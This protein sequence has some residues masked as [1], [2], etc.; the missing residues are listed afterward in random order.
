MEGCR[1]RAGSGARPVVAGIVMVLVAA[2]SVALFGYLGFLWNTARGINS[3]GHR[4]AI[5]ELI[6]PPSTPS[7]A[8]TPDTTTFSG[9]NLLVVGND[10][11]SAM[12]DA[13]VRELKVG[14]DGGSLAT[15]TMLIIHVPADGSK[16][17][18]IS[19]PRDSYVTIPGF[20]A[21][22]LNAA[23][24][25]AYHAES[26]NVD[27]KRA[28]GADLLIKVVKNLTGVSI[29]HFVQV[30]L[31]GFVTI[32]DAVHGIPINLCHSV[33]DTVAHNRTLGIEGG[34]GFKMSAGH[35]SIQGVQ[36]LEF[37]RQRHHLPGEDIGR[38]ARQRY[39]LAAAFRTVSA[40]LL[41]DIGRLRS[42]INALKNSIYTDQDL[43]FL[44]LAQQLS[45]LSAN[46][47]RGGV[48]PTDHYADVTIDWF[49]PVN[50]GVVYPKAVRAYVRKLLGPSA[51]PTTAAPVTTGPV[52][53]APRTG[54]SSTKV[55]TA[56]DSGCID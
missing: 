1:H 29:T 34:S 18:L 26:G 14:R 47:I 46:S 22:K 56:V 51:A 9:Q 17:T 28:A 7:G 37:V 48:I 21:A 23:Y 39:F 2:L 12:T 49:F 42:V 4:L 45:A 38:A 41:L 3:G 19:L 25:D 36:A 50:V 35:H 52:T 8:A 5:P 27:A 15:D 43:N 6:K 11:R 44:D 33:D 13:Q 10:D 54:S 40:G 53:T 20:G 16:A 55:P 24:G 30:S 31:L 32:S